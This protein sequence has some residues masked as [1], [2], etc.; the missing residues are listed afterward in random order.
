MSYIFP[1]AILYG[2]FFSRDGNYNNNIYCIKNNIIVYADLLLEYIYNLILLQ[3]NYTFD[4][5]SEYFFIAFIDNL[6]SDY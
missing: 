6:F 3:I 4:I 1:I 5:G 2:T